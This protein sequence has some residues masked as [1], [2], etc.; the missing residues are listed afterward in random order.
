MKFLEAYKLG[1]CQRLRTWVEEAWTSEGGEVKQDLH[2]PWI[3]KQIIGRLGL[4]FACTKKSKETLLVTCGGRP[5][6]F[7]WPWC[8]RYEI[9][10][11]MWDCWPRY[12][13]NLPRILK[14]MHVRTIFCTSSQTADYVRERC[15]GIKAIWLPE[16]IKVDLYPMGPRLTERRHDVLR[17]GR[18]ADGTI[19]Y[20][21]HEE[22]TAAMRD[23]RIM[24]CRPRCDTDPNMAGNIE[25][26]T[27]R[28]WEA[29]LS[30]CVIVGRA[31]KEL[32]SICSYNPVV[33]VKEED[34]DAGVTKVLRHLS[35]YQGLVDRNRE[36]AARNADWT[37]RI[38][39]IKAE[40]S[41]VVDCSLC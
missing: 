16:G 40:I 1:N 21:T 6:Y 7:A 17:I 30:G 23:S 37:N 25:T 8:Y 29:M 41:S 36:F 13:P 15:P 10:P 39:L 2:L 9:V 34:Y 4:C 24:I 5:E 27:Q 22:L 28:Y 11:I 14:K 18:D 33:E 31:P 12:Q 35:D 38:R 32:I 3:V 20:Q 19:W 26:L